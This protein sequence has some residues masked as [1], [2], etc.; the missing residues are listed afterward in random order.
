[1]KESYDF[2]QGQ[3]GKF[4]HPNAEFELPIYLDSDIVTFLQN[5]ADAKGTDIQTIANDWIRKNI[6]LIETAQ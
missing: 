4:Y 2:S 1:M 5:I 3:R 6:A